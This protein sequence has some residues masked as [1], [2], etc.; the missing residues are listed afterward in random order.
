MDQGGEVLLL[1]IRP[2]LHGAVRRLGRWGDVGLGGG[3]LGGVGAYV[4]VLGG[5]R[6]VLSWRRFRMAGRGLF[7]GVG[8]VWTLACSIASDG[9]ST[10]WLG[11]GS[12]S[13]EL[14]HRLRVARERAT[15]IRQLSL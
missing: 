8:E 10:V 3:G 11:A 14:P 9:A 12:A 4:D 6:D 1:R 2:D 5:R 7:G 15:P 13:V